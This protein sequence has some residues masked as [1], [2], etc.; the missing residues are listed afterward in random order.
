MIGSQIG[1]GSGKTA[2]QVAGAVG[3]ALA[4]WEIEK[5]VGNS[6]HYEVLMRLEN[7]GAQT[8]STPVD[9]GLRAGEKVRIVDG[10]LARMCFFGSLARST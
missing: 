3:G 4:G 1:G 5:R 9:S 7:S 6:A 10:G 8:I 2:T